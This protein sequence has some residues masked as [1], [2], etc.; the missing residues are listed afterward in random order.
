[1]SEIDDLIAAGTIVMDGGAAARRS[2]AERYRVEELLDDRGRLIGIRYW[3]KEEQDDPFA[4]VNAARSGL[5]H[6]LV[7][8]DVPRE[9]PE[10]D[11][12]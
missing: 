5:L 9:T 6:D 11:D 7:V 1:M 3:A 10:E 8:A 2:M 12:R 4:M